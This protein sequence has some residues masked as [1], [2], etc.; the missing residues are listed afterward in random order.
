MKRASLLAGA[1]IAASFTLASADSIPNRADA[2]LAAAV[3]APLNVSYTGIVEELRIGGHAAEASVYRIEHLAPDRTRRLYT[4]PSRLSGDAIVS[5]GDLIFS[6]DAKRRRIVETQNKAIDSPMAV[7]ADFALL[8]RNY[9]MI[10]KSDEVFDGRRTIDLVFVNKYSGRPTV[11]LRIDA[12]SKLML[13]KE[14]FAS[15]GALVDE[16]RFEEV[17][18]T[19]SIPRSD[20]GLP[21]GYSVVQGPLFGTPSGHPDQIVRDAG[22]AA[23]EPRA[24]PDG[25]APVE[26]DLVQLHGVRTVQ[27]LYSDGVRTVSLF[28]NVKSSMVDLKRL[29]PQAVRVGAGTAQYADD[30]ETSLLAWSEGDLCYTLV[31]ELGLVDLQ[32]IA[33]SI[34]K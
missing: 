3:S 28:E 21:A 31:G 29:Q 26:G 23:W 19:S 18:F 16:L 15:D 17:R 10:R 27:L 30:G 11:L 25:F 8:D 24:L 14:E 20:F 34:G 13:D 5:K 4:S 33:Q 9:R 12:A 22:F 6:I 1:L 7:D 2:L 32:R